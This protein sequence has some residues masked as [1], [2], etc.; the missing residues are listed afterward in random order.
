[1]SDA[2]GLPKSLL[3]TK[4]RANCSPCWGAAKQGKTDRFRNLLL[5]QEKYNEQFI[6]AP[7][8]KGLVMIVFTLPTHD[9][10]IKN[11][12]R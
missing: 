9:I 3:P 12:P 5:H 8:E 1:V 4:P 11:H 10:V 6:H 7:G 2:G